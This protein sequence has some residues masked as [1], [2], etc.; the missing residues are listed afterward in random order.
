MN[1]LPFAAQRA[2]SASADSPGPFTMQ[3]ITAMR[4]GLFTVVSN[5][6]TCLANF[7]TSIWH[8]P[9][10]GHTISSG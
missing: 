8:R 5:F 10:V 1:P 9:H 6:L 3:P 2:K 7:T 4:R